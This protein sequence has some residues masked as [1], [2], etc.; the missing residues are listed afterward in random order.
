MDS[1]A[2]GEVL[3]ADGAF[4]E[5]GGGIDGLLV[6]PWQGVPRSSWATVSPAVSSSCQYATSPV[7]PMISIA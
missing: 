4:N 5:R 2:P 3:G 6:D 7:V 1:L